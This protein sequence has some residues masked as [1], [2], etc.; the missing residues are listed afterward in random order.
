M[1]ED[2]QRINEL[3][4]KVNELFVKEAKSIGDAINV[5]SLMSA[6]FA[7]RMGIDKDAYLNDI[8]IMYQE[9]IDNLT[10]TVDA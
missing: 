6:A 8:A 3:Y 9:Q 5:C 1:N 2:Q 7:V 4:R 10:K